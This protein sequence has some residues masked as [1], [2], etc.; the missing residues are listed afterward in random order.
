MKIDLKSG[1][2]IEIRKRIQDFNYE[3]VIFTKD[4]K[5]IVLDMDPD[6]W[7]DIALLMHKVSNNYL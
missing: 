4:K 7:K 2:T 5:V 1:V 3:L 6:E